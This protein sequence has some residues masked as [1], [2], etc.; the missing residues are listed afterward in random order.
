[1]FVINIV[2][3]ALPT[4]A[5]PPQSKAVTPI[6][7][8]I[9]L[10]QFGNVITSWTM[11]YADTYMNRS[12]YTLI[13]NVIL[14]TSN[15]HTILQLNTVSHFTLTASSGPTYDKSSTFP[16]FTEPTHSI[17]SLADLHLSVAK[18]GNDVDI[19]ILLYVLAVVVFYGLLL[20]IALMCQRAQ[21]RQRAKPEDD[22]ASLI[23]RNEIVRKD[24]VLRQKMNVLRLS[25]VQQG[26]ML[27]QIPSCEVWYVIRWLLICFQ[28]LWFI[29]HEVCTPIHRC[30]KAIFQRGRK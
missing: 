18:D 19:Q 28:D 2:I 1:M 7:F 27:D 11:D 26:Y 8:G 13:D 17:R 4:N 15:D 30:W 6:V 22:H 29:D 12:S 16:N 20:T 9:L 23:D 5:H 14:T 24:T 10:T 21:R 25:G 3:S